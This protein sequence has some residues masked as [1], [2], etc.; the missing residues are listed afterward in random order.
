VTGPAARRLRNLART[1]RWYVNRARSMSPRE[2]PYRAR[3][4]LRMR[5]TGGFTLESGAVDWDAALADR[6]WDDL[7]TVDGVVE[8]WAES[9]AALRAGR[10]EVFGRRWPTG[11][12][13]IPR[14]DAPGPAGESEPDADDADWPLV[15][16]HRIDYRHGSTPGCEVRAN[17]EVQRLLYL[18]P[19]ACHARL[20]GDAAL[21]EVIRSH[22]RDWVR[23]HPQGIGV[24]WGTAIETAL[25][26]VALALVESL[27]ADVAP[28]PEFR[29]LTVAAVRDHLAWIR[30][31]PSLYSSANNHRVAELMGLLVG[32]A[33]AHG[34]LSPAELRAAADELWTRLLALFNADGGGAEQA[35][36]YGLFTLEMAVLAIRA[37]DALAIPAAPEVRARIVAAVAFDADLRNVA[38]TLLTCGDDDSS[39]VHLAA[40]PEASVSRALAGTA[41]CPPPE[42]SR[43]RTYPETGITVARQR[44]GDRLVEM[45]FDHGP[46]GFGQLAAHAHS[47]CL[48]VWL[49]VDGQP[50]FAEAGTYGYHSAGVWRELF[51]SAE[52]HNTLRL[53][54]LEPSVS[55]GPFNWHPTARARGRLLGAEHDG[56]SFEITGAHDGYLK[57][58]GVEH[59]RSL[60]YR[61]GRLIVQD[62]LAG[63][64]RTALGDLRYLVPGDVKV[65]PAVLGWTLYRN[66]E[67]I[68]SLRCEGTDAQV[69]LLS[70]QQGEQVPYSPRFGTLEPAH[71]L[72]FRAR[73]SASH[74]MRTV[75]TFGGQP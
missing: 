42:R 55:S 65:E 33:T 68:C 54:G 41:G 47:D 67:P 52:L 10:V 49:A 17:W 37:A 3:E 57:R 34:A 35:P 53:D 38:D 71:Q 30:A 75:I 31:F 61:D 11:P 39:H 26:L 66:G 28:D 2:L 18:L 59:R 21:V 36:G 63:S 32:G 29:R 4:Q 9:A 50:V 45:W 40:V 58:L 6:L 70:S 62:R 44:V 7:R 73:I 25:R 56:D 15:W 12:D 48:A 24:A 60:T 16:A 74:P 23:L 14:W 51:R 64:P 19:A 46:L 22:V 20:S 1:A 8:F 72:V 69:E 27:T 43:F 13:G 5:S